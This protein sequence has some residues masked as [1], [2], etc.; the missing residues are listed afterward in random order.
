[1]IRFSQRYKE[2]VFTSDGN[3][4]DRITSLNDDT[5]YKKKKRI[6][7]LLIQFNEP[8]KLKRNRYSKETVESG[9]FIYALQSFDHDRGYSYF[10]SY[11]YGGSDDYYNAVQILEGGFSPYLFD[12]IEYQYEILSAKEKREFTKAINGLF[13]DLDMPWTLAEGLLVK[14][15]AAQFEMDLKR[16]TERLMLELKDADPAF[17]PAF[18][19]LNKAM[20][21][22]QKGDFH[23]AIINADKSYESVIKTVLNVVRGK[24]DQMLT[25]ISAKLDLPHSVNPSGFKTNVLASLPYIRNN[26]SGHGAGSNEV[27]A[28][29][30]LANLA[31][32]LACSLITYLIEEYRKNGGTEDA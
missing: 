32:N 20:E 30:E 15:D 26:V 1:M 28:S 31:I 14:I 11:G 12:I 25:D 9:A 4:D 2:L 10:L 6:V 23:E 27:V 8:I 3:F 22:L 5:S 18:D 17:Q 29:K 13:L 24:P 7:E 21:F 19:E 16:K